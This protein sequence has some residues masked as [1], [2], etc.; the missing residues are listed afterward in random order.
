MIDA[1]ILADLEARIDAADKRYGPF[2]SSHE[3]LG[4]ITEEYS[5][6][7]DA[8]RSNDIAAIQSEAIDLA[9]CCIRLAMSLEHKATQDRSVK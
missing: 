9:A 7:I 6:L 8:I 3:A 1:F 4:V 5:E 2:A